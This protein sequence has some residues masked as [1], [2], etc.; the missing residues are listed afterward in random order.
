M[1]RRN[2]RRTLRYPASAAATVG[3]PLVFL[4]LFVYVFGDTLG[5]GLPGVSGGRA[6]YLN[7]VTPGIIAARDRRRGARRRDLGLDGHDRGHHRP[8]PDDGD[9]P[10]LGPH[11]PRR[12]QPD[13]D[14][15]RDRA[16]HRH[17]ARARVRTQR[18]GARMARGERPAGHGDLRDDLAVGRARAG[19]QERRDREQP[20]HAAVPAPVPRQRLRAHRHDA[21]R[22]ALVRREPALHADH[23]DRPRTAARHP[24]RQQRRPRRRLVGRRSGSAAT[25]GPS[26]SS[27]ATPWPR[28]TKGPPRPTRRPSRGAGVA[29]RS[30]RQ[31][32]DRSRAGASPT[33][34][35]SWRS[36][37]W[38]CWCWAG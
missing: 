29:R 12:R 19:Q 28:T 22:D 1:L 27:T 31:R 34:S 32:C 7:Y 4:L 36:G 13:P 6:E 24:D 33:A 26:T 10:R 17:R 38:P 25:C 5:A 9:R 16:R 21:H 20:P 15:A 18:H 3:I 8:L 23:G 37:C 11:R 14:A 30:M 2:L 35:G